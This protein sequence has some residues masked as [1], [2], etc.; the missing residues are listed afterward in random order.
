MSL[1]RLGAIFGVEFRHS[2]RRPLFIML[3]VLLALT[4]LGLSSGNMTISS[5]DSEVGGTK[6]WI[7]SQF[8]QTQMMTFIILLIYGFFIGWAAGFT[9]MRDRETKVDAL[10]HST[11]LTPGEYVWG[12]FLAVIAGFLILMLFQVALSSFFNHVIARS[13]DT[14]ISSRSLS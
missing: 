14:M 1:R 2:F 5:G 11:P 9:L 12:R 7:T 10:L 3:A 8:A 13:R 4:V 6:A